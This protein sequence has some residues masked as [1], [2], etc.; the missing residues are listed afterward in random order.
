VHAKVT[1]R[2]I[3]IVVMDVGPVG[4]MER[5]LSELIHGFLDAGHH[6]NVISRTCDVG[7]SDP[8]LRHIRVRLPRRPYALVFPIWVL[9]ATF[10]TWRTRGDAV[11]VNGGIILNRADVYTMHFCHRAYQSMASAGSLGRGSAL[12]RLN[13]WV[14]RWYKRR[15]EAWALRP[16][17]VG[18]IVAI[19]A[20]V[21][22]ETAQEYPEVADRIRVIPYGLDHSRFRVDPPARATR[23]QE[24]GLAAEDL[25]AV[26]VG[27]D[28]ERKGLSTIIRALPAAQAWHLLVVGVGDRAEHERVAAKAGVADR[29]HFLGREMLPEQTYNAADAFVFPTAYETFSLVTHEAAACGLPLLVSKVYGV[30]DLLEAGVSGWFVTRDPDDI[31]ARLTALVDPG[32]RVAMGQA[33]ARAAASYDWRLA[34]TA[35]LALYDA[36]LDADPAV[37]SVVCSESGREAPSQRAGS[38]RPVE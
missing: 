37:P 26:F 7:R 9:L 22:R 21:G 4:G 32:L 33:A 17:R 2:T 19:S 34:V 31:A 6:V 11:H 24:L 5:Q 18:V 3:T 36:Q 27:G 35:H 29:V 20:G 15:L 16:D 25:A 1:P 10:A 13:G 12:Y 28:W 30:E 38:H 23:R 14:G 8:H